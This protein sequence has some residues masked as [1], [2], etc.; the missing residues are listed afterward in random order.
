MRSQPSL[1]NL[2]IEK[3]PP[4]TSCAGCR[5][6]TR[7]RD[8]AR[9]QFVAAAHAL[10]DVASGCSPASLRPSPVR[11]LALV[12]ELC[13][14]LSCL[15]P[16]SDGSARWFRR[17]GEPASRVRFLTGRPSCRSGSRYARPIRARHAARLDGTGSAHTTG[18]A[19]VLRCANGSHNVVCARARRR[20]PDRARTSSPRYRTTL[21]HQAV[22]LERLAQQDG[23]AF[24][25][26]GRDHHQMRKR[27]L[28]DNASAARHKRE[29]RKPERGPAECHRGSGHSREAAERRRGAGACVGGVGRARCR[30]GIC[31][32]CGTKAFL[33]CSVV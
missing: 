16:P 15:C 3:D 26:A 12:A 25:V 14:F 31:S 23:A 10:E 19:L 5:S 24:A 18:G 17:Q 33:W 28:F 32:C 9:A 21:Y 6:G 4:C 7:S 11:K 2:L 13:H 27:P 30:I 1:A 22:D 29:R 20:A 8:S